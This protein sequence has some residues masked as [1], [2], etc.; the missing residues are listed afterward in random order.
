MHYKCLGIF[1]LA[2]LLAI[3]CCREV[4]TPQVV[5]TREMETAIVRPYLEHI[6]PLFPGAKVIVADGVHVETGALNPG[7]IAEWVQIRVPQERENYFGIDARVMLYGSEDDATIDF[8]RN[9]RDKWWTPDLP[10]FVVKGP[11]GDRCVVSYNRQ[12]P[13]GHDVPFGC[14]PSDNYHSFVM[15]QKGRLVV[16]IDEYS[17]KAD[18]SRK[19]AVMSQIAEK[20][21]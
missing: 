9:W 13:T 21:R 6:I 11:P 17:D 15:F 2:V 18:G 5:D 19:E 4:I 8:E 16:S 3:G 1:E 20:L 14:R 7:S 10:R 12:S